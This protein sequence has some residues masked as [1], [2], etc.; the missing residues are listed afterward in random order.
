MPLSNY[1]DIKQKSW[2]NEDDRIE[3]LERQ[4]I[5]TKLN[6]FRKIA[7]AEFVDNGD[8]FVNPNIGPMINVNN[9]FTKINSSG[10]NA[11]TRTATLDTAVENFKAGRKLKYYKE[12]DTWDKAYKYNASTGAYTDVRTALNDATANDVTWDFANVNDALYLAATQAFSGVKINVGTAGVY[13]G[14]TMVWEYYSSSGWKELPYSFGDLTNGLKNSGTKYVWFYLPDDFAPLTLNSQANKYWVRLRVA[15]KST[16]SLVTTSP[17]ITQSWINMQYKGT[18]VV[19]SGSTST[20]IVVGAAAIDGGDPANNYRCLRD[21]RE[22]RTAMKYIIWKTIEPTTR[23]T[24]EWSVLLTENLSSLNIILHHLKNI[25]IVW[26]FV[27]DYPTSSAHRDI[28]DWFYIDAVFNLNPGSTYNNTY[29]QGFA[30][31][32]SSPLLIAENERIT[33]KLVADLEGL[34]ATYAFQIGLIG[35]WGE[36]HH[37]DSFTY[38]DGSSFPD[39]SITDQYIQ[40]YIDYVCPKY[41]VVC[42]RSYG[43]LDGLIG[44]FNDGLGSESQVRKDTYMG[45]IAGWEN[46]YTNLWDEVRYVNVTAYDGNKTITVSNTIDTDG[47]TYLTGKSVRIG[48]YRYTV[49][50]AT[51]GT[52]G[53]A[54]VTFTTQPT[55]KP[56]SGDVAYV[57]THEPVKNFRNIA[58]VSGE[59]I[60]PALQDL[61]GFSIGKVL[62]Y[63]G[64]YTDKTT[65]ANSSNANDVEPP[66][67]A[68]NDA[69]YIG[70][71]NGFASVRVTMGTNGNYTG[72]AVYE[73]WNGSS[74]AT[75]TAT[76]GTAT[77]GKPWTKSGT[78]SFNA[79]SDWAK[80][81]V[82][83]S[84]LYWIRCRLTAA[85]TVTTAPKITQMWFNSS[86]YRENWSDLWYP[87][88]KAQLQDY[89]NSLLGYNPDIGSQALNGENNI[90]DMLKILGYRLYVKRA[91]LLSSGSTVSNGDIVNLDMLIYNAGI[92]RFYDDWDIEVSL[93]NESESVA[94]KSILQVKSSILNKGETNIEGSF[95]VNVPAGK[96]ALA[97][98]IIDPMTSAPGVRF[99][100]Q[101]RTDLR[102]KL[103][104]FVVT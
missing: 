13:H 23:N 10:W 5:A 93:I 75:L 43:I 65:E 83:S 98:G 92:A 4:V 20:A 16:D 71:E 64:S 15:E 70:N 29:G 66:F 34:P 50:S 82:N 95:T 72:T 42:R 26:R 102:H 76:D 47:A 61:N 104:K 100:Q 22:F 11:G 90:D 79:P 35:H 2:R 12:D 25:R 62:L 84:S 94:Q 73:Y 87:T 18:S 67:A 37:E 30:P 58:P 54:T 39:Q 59:P 60:L 89:G 40:H 6:N 27:Y 55:K 28:P 85:P 9:A 44:G 57:I 49:A 33:Q 91:S 80:T 88:F 32:Y 7:E 36:N 63:N 74:W 68:E 31:N 48:N 1:S 3:E 17:K 24:F 8:V 69:L 103:F 99:A 53:T 86:N 51:D 46:G 77:S 21:D 96:Y 81:T 45:A 101:A 38:S 41:H 78:I 56:I 14:F 19:Q 52:G 97:I